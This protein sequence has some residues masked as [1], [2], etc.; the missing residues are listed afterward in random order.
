MPTKHVIAMLNS[1]GAAQGAETLLAMPADRIETL[2]NEMSPADVGRLLH[3]ARTDRKAD[4]LAV[5]GPKRAPAVLGRFSIHQL[6][7]LVASLPLP[8]AVNLLHSMSPA[9]AADLLLEIPT[10]RRLLL[11][12]ALSPR[13]PDEFSS[14]VYQREVEESVVRIASRASWL[15]QVAGHLLA[16]VMGRPFQIVVRYRPEGTFTGDDLRDA[17]GRVDWRRV[18]GMLVLTNALPGEDCSAV[19][20]ELRQF[21][22]AV[23]VVRWVNEADDGLF[24]KALVRLV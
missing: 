24:K 17:A 22:H 12:D 18:T 19:I 8:G 11:Q 15:D 2:M 6:A 20:R 16:E 9:A 10:R 23:D 13:Q 4:L 3:G 14:A 21:G 7:D 1:V 5:I